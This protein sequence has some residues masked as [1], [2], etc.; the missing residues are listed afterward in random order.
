MFKTFI[1]A[2]KV[3]D[4]RLKL[5]FTLLM[6]VVVRLGC[7]IPA[8]GVSQEFVKAM[9]G[10]IF[11]E[12]G[13]GGILGRFTG[14]S[15]EKMSIFA[16]NITPYITSSIIM[17]LMTI[18]I[19][20]LEEMQND[21]EDG[22]KKIASITRYVTI[23][24]AL[25]E[26]GAM[27]IGFG[28]QGLIT[29]YN[30]LSVL[31]VIAAMTA[32]SAFLMWAGERITEKGVG[33][34]I[35]IV[36][37]INIISSF[38]EDAKTLFDQFVLDN[39]VAIGVLNAVLIILVVLV[40]IVLVI[41]LS[42][43]TRKIPLQ[44]A[45]KIQG[46]KMMGGNTT[47]IP[48][49]I[50]T[51]GVMPVIFASSILQFPIIISQM[52]GY[53]GAGW[54]NEALK[55]MNARYW[56]NKNDFIYTL[57]VIAYVAMCIFFAYFYTS[58]TFNPIEIANNLKKAGGFVPG[59]RPGKPTSDYLNTVLNYIIFIGAIGLT[60]VAIY[61]YVFSGLFGASVSFGGTSIIIVVGVIIETVKQVESQ[62]IVRNYKGFLND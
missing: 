40:L 19:P 54:W 14:G 58:I 27:A 24:L 16:L 33:N 62:M 4:I 61:P 2:F 60:I 49:K 13:V 43:A 34:G 30:A 57:G 37:I 35:S 42:D 59:I 23:G 26:S 15:F 29:D 25:V 17:Q 21:G 22:R 28:S 20:K 7:Q 38:P 12:D 52:V 31:T 48:I 46:N 36:L 41:I 1:N 6:L 18:A 10:N 53:S 45:K 55:F 5:L 39:S 56:F 8:P 44:Y 47:T 9:M 3:K 32:G 50:N 51:A 11:G